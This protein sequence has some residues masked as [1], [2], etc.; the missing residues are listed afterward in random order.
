M[1]TL[2]IQTKPAYPVYIGSDL[3]RNTGS[4]VQNLGDFERVCVVTDDNVEKLYLQTVLD[5]FGEKVQTASIV[6]PHG[7]QSKCLASLGKLYDFFADQKM[8]RSDL[9]IALGGGVVGDLTG[10]AASSFLRGVKYVQIPTTLLAQVDSSV[11][12]KTAIDIP[13]G[14]NL[15]GSFYQPSAVL[16]DIDTLS[17]LSDTIF[18]DGCAEIIKYACIYDASLF[19]LIYQIHDRDILEKIITRCLEIK[20]EVV[21]EDEKDTGVRMILNFGHTLGHAVEKKYHFSTY[22]HGQGVAI[23]MVKITKLSEK[24]GLTAPG[25][26]KKIAELCQAM[27]LPIDCEI[28]NEELFDICC[29][30]KKNLH[31]MI[32]LILLKEIG[33][34]FIHK[35]SREE[36]SDFLNQ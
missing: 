30:D 34:C 18:S 12:G 21:A 7:E 22:T 27:K 15:V 36:F 28:S 9:I 35:L 6:I 25:T 14:K 4:L 10:F 32:H 20:A 33:S 19:D 29:L 2:T 24:A 31:H 3:I 17:T 11:G 1:H 16:C 13:A 26:V 23:G 5:S 8:T